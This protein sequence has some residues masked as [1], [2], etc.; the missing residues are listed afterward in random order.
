MSNI[1]LHI[2]LW[3]IGYLRWYKN[4][5]NWIPSLNFFWGALMVVMCGQYLR[6][7]TVQIH[8]NS[9]P[10]HRGQ[11]LR[12]CGQLK[13]NWNPNGKQF[14]RVG[15]RLWGVLCFF[16]KVVCCIVGS[17]YENVDN[18][19]PIDIQTE[20]NLYVW[21]HVYEEFSVFFQ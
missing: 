14:V 16:H 11:Y 19:N 5:K 9:C 17:I 1:T 4:D 13:F 7:I 20:N 2:F 21:E 8:T 10:L 15:T 18:W 3:Y 6:I 12:E